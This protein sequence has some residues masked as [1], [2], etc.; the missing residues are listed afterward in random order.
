M[1][2]EA[3]SACLRAEASQRAVHSVEVLGK[4]SR[5]MSTEEVTLA[6]STSTHL[7]KAIPP[8]ARMP[9]AHLAALAALKPTPDSHPHGRS[10]VD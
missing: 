5:R 1:E 10:R 3:T 7:L 4:A 9:S 8:R 6:A 2:Q